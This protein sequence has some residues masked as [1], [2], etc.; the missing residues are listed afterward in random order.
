MSQL[1]ILIFFLND[2]PLVHSNAW[3]DTLC[4]RFFFVSGENAV[5]D[6]AREESINPTNGLVP[7]AF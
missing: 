4:M 7:V 1:W 5:V 2:N 6:G 3:H